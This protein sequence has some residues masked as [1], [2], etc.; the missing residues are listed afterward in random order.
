[1]RS[2]VRGGLALLNAPGAGAN[3]I[4]RTATEPVGGQNFA[5]PA[6]ETAMDIG[7]A[8]GGV[9]T[10]ASPAAVAKKLQAL[11]PRM[12]AAISRATQVVNAV[13]AGGRLTPE[14][15]NA[16]KSITKLLDKAATLTKPGDQ[17][18]LVNR[19]VGIADDFRRTRNL[20]PSAAIEALRDLGQTQRKLATSYGTR[21]GIRQGAAT[22][23]KW[24]I[25]GALVLQFRDALGR[26]LLK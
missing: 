7:L 4:A 12:A 13:P 17:A 9:R 1:V 8:A 15:A 5:G 6:A 10:L 25:P 2:L 23:A 11:E 19:A 24:L 14:A 22:A 18:N 3:I 26:T 21:M 16:A 20:G